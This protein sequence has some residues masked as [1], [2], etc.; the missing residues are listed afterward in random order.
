MK[1]HPLHD[2]RVEWE[3]KTKG[4]TIIPDIV[5]EKAQEAETVAVGPGAR[6]ESGKLTVDLK[7][8]DRVLFAKWSDS[9]VRIAG[10]D[11]LVIMKKSD[12]MGVIE[13]AAAVE[14]AA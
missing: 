3:D 8:G 1:F 11:G 6:G 7:K 13:G 12:I 4:S 2:R 14:K 10:Q 5:K 9:E